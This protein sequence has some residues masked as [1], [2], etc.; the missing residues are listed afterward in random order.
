MKKYLFFLLL[1]GFTTSVFSQTVPPNTRLFQANTVK[2]SALSQV[3]TTDN[4]VYHVGT[5]N[6]SEVGFDGLAAT[7]VGFDDLFI[8]KS[9]SAN[10]SNLWFK[11]FNAG[12]KGTIA[13]RYISV[14]SN[15]NLYHR[16]T[17]RPTQGA[18]H[19]Q[20]TGEHRLRRRLF[21]RSQARPLPDARRR[22]RTH[23]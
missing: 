14:D 1:F 19:L 6:S 21:L 12:N 13:P 17:G 10:G 18:H 8:L 7:S 3:E 4:F 20:G 5:V 16:P 2:G 11:T 22:G 9:S 15:E 23:G